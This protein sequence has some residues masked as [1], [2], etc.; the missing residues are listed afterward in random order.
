MTVKKS[1]WVSEMRRRGWGQGKRE[2]GG[3]MGKGRGQTESEVAC[4]IADDGEGE[5]V[6]WEGGGR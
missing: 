5:G 4:A 3:K 1:E 2:E 6:G